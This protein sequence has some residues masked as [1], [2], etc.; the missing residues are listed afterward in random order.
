MKV[1]NYRQAT[2]IVLMLISTG[3]AA[4]A[5]Y[6]PA[7]AFIAQI[8]LNDAWRQHQLGNTSAKPWSWADTKPLAKLYHE[9]LGIEQ[10]ILAGASG[11]VL[12]F[13]PA[14]VT[15]SGALGGK[16]NAVISGHRDTHFSW[17]A[18]VEN[19]DYLTVELPNG[20]HTKYAVYKQEIRHE[21]E[22]EILDAD[23]GV[24]LKLVTCYPFNAVVS[25]G[26]LRYVVNAKPVLM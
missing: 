10:I 12:A 7:K 14:H 24:G 2:F 21:R 18:E 13:A 23:T 16:M 9:R 11:R 8:L 4:K 17:L 26:P 6:I 5:A 25:G 19:G 3:L 20:Q 1:L 15:G 22:T